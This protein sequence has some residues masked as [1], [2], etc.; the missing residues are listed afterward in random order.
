[1]DWLNKICNCTIPLCSM[2]CEDRTSHLGT[3]VLIKTSENY[4]L[5]S[6]RHV[7]ENDLNVIDKTT[8]KNVVYK[9]DNDAYPISG[10]FVCYCEENI[11]IIVCKLDSYIKDIFVAENLENI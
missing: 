8:I 11:D 10:K 9:K 6:A 7:F 5:L 2:D 3:G 4:Y 1:M